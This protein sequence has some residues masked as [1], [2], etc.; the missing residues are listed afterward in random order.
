ML[1]Q[2]S[3]IQSYPKSNALHDPSTTSLHELYNGLIKEA[4]HAQKLGMRRNTLYNFTINHEVSQPNRLS[5]LKVDQESS[6]GLDDLKHMVKILVI[7]VDDYTSKINDLDTK[8]QKLEKTNNELEFKNE[9][10]K[11]KNDEQKKKNS[12]LELNI[13]MLQHLSKTKV[14]ENTGKILQLQNKVGDLDK[15]NKL[16]EKKNRQLEMLNEQQT[17]KNNALE[18]NVKMLQEL[19]KTLVVRSCEELARHGITENG[20]YTIDPDGE[21]NG[22]DPIQVHCKFDSGKAITEIGHFNEA[23]INVEK[24][25]EVGC[26]R[27]KMTYNV[28]MSQIASLISI[29]SECV[30]KIG[31]G[32][33]LAPLMANDV[34]MGG[35]FDRNGNTVRYIKLI[36]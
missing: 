21:L 13:K 19:S 32:C 15:K 11:Y 28:P 10:I 26:F 34:K 33:F 23:L 2:L 31:F 36:A 16:L 20:I 18:M 8:L 3:V 9:E 25:E 4:A 35:W 24:C 29:S 6:F 1:L 22:S 7:T 30:Q 12:E 27:Q 14:D 5:P 17:R